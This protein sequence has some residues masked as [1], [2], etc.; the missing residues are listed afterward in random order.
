ML[1]NPA[2]AAK[3]YG[4]PVKQVMRWNKREP[5]PKEPGTQD[6]VPLSEFDAYLWLKGCLCCK[7]IMGV[8]AKVPWPTPEL[9]I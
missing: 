8:K 5:W 2:Q 3:F 4:L 1:N 6:P 7:Q 9:I